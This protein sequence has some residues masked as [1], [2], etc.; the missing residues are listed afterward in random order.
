MRPEALGALDESLRATNVLSED[1]RRTVFAMAAKAV[2]VA[3]DRGRAAAFEQA[4]K[5]L[6]GAGMA[7]AADQIY[8]R[9]IGR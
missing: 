1:Y 8:G 2:E 9:H 7:A 5:E 6:R 4:A 3:Y